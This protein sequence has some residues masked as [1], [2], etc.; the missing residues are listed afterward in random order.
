M[1]DKRPAWA[2]VG[3]EIFPEE[4]NEFLATQAKKSSML[5]TWMPDLGPLPPLGCIAQ[6]LMCVAG[7]LLWLFLMYRWVTKKSPGQD[8]EQVSL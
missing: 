1:V 5:E 7:L 2:R 4:R 8:T 6:A 3:M